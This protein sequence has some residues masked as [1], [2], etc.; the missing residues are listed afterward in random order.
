[1][2]AWGDWVCSAI[3]KEAEEAYSGQ[4]VFEVPPEPRVKDE[5]SFVNKAITR[6]KNYDDP[7]SQIEDQVGVRFVVLLVDQVRKLGK[8]IEEHPGWR[9]DK[10]RDVD[11]ERLDRP[12]HFDY[13]SMHYVVR[14]LSN[15]TVENTVIPA[16]TACEVQVRTLLQHAYAQ[17][18]HDLLYKPTLA[19][20]PEIS[21]CVARSMA[22][23]ETT[24]NLFMEASRESL[25]ASAEIDRILRI[26]RD[27]FP[28]RFGRGAQHETKIESFILD[29]YA[30]F[31]SE[32]EEDT[33]NGVSKL[34][35]LKSWRTGNPD[36]PLVDLGVCIAVFALVKE[37]PRTALEN[38]PLDPAFLEPIYTQLGISYSA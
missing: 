33:L 32:I 16:G 34:N 3:K 14:S 6:G 11:Q 1:M 18:S 29:R 37:Y 31:L 20:L 15:I 2:K 10:A 24:D 7:L 22:L 21:R 12:F 13:Q 4:I 36:H 5:E 9:W 23:I 26:C 8:V 38:W 35:S 28:L 27:L 17:L 25:K 19:T 30:G